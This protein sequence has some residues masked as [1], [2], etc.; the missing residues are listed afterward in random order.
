MYRLIIF[1]YLIL[2]F[3]NYLSFSQDLL[4]K[5]GIA[6]F[7]SEKLHN[8]KTASGEIYN[9]N[10][11]TAAH[12][13]LPFNTLI[14]VTNLI[15]GKSVIVRINDRGPFS[16]TRIIDISKAAA[17]E[18]E[19][20]NKGTVKVRIELPEIEEQEPVV[21]PIHQTEEQNED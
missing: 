18:L 7:Y 11:L 5:E 12:P 4:P 9:Q 15:N 21:D 14:K 16:S 10:E 8:K 3:S 17:K 6:S 1:F 13:T 2:S 19:M 20:I